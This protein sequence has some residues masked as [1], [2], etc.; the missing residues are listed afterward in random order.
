MRGA[1]GMTE[2]LLLVLVSLPSLASLLHPILI[3]LARRKWNRSARRVGA[4]EPAV[5]VVV[6]LAPTEEHGA[7]NMRSV[8]RQGGLRDYQVVFVAEER[9]HASAA[10]ARAAA[11]AHPDV[12]TAIVYSGDPQG[13]LAKMHNL[14]AGLL[15]CR[16]EVVVFVDSDVGFLGHHDIRRLVRILADD[17][18]GLVTAAPVYRAPRTLG[19]YLLATMI[20]VDLWAYFSGLFLSGSMNVANGALLAARGS[21]LAGIG[22]LDDLQQQ[23]LNDTALARKVRAAGRLVAL[24]GVPVYVRTPSLTVSAWWRQVMRWHIG[25]RR[26]LPPVE[27][28]LYGYHRSAMLLGT[29]CFLLAG[30]SPIRP[31]FLAVPAG[32]R[33][34]S[35]AVLSLCW[36]RERRALPEVFLAVLTDLLSPG[37]W[38]L[39]WM[40]TTVQWRGRTYRIGKG[41]TTEEVHR[42]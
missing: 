30:P 2:S 16:G 20:N 32:A 10:L 26:V 12:D 33:L 3:A 22:D 17:R 31:W 24:S 27:Y 18:V 39:S 1:A 35:C 21:F 23:L 38:L 8:L 25:M 13:R 19:G 11:A 15:L 29:I 42:A 28:V 14:Q 36:W 40:Q 9:D 37:I 41:G 7:D 34:L 6:P 4:W 5:S